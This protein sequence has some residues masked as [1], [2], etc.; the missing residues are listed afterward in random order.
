MTSPRFGSRSNK[1]IR[2]PPNASRFTSFIASRHNFR[3]TPKWDDPA[4]FR[5][6]ANS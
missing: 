2:Q 4:E 5:A 1:T 6:R 3:T